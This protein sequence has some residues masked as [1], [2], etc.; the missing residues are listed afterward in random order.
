MGDMYKNQRRDRKRK[1]GMKN[2]QRGEERQIEMERRKE[3]AW[4]KREEKGKKR[5][6]NIL[7]KRSAPLL[8]H[9]R[10]YDRK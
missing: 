6:E 2:T 3:N 9:S 8:R 7:L 10:V 1:R 4:M 5:G